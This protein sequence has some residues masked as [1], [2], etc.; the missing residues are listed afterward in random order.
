MIWLVHSARF[1]SSQASSVALDEVT[2]GDQTRIRRRLFVLTLATWFCAVILTGGALAQKTGGIL[3]IYNR[4]SAPSM[5]ILEEST[6][7]TVLPMM[8]VFNNLVVY[9]QHVAQNSEQS[10]LPDLATSWSWSEDGTQ[11]TFRLREGVKWHDG[12]PFTAKD[13][14]CT[15]DLLTDR[16][17]EKL[18]INPRRSWYSN[19][20][21]LVTNGD[22][23]A[24]FVLKRPQPALLALLASGFAPIYP[25][26]VSPREMRAHP[27]GTGP[28]KFVEFRPNEGI[29]VTRNPD[30]WKKG[31]P[32]LDGIE[33]TIIPNRSTALL[34]FGAGKFDM[35]WPY[36]VAIPLLKDVQNQTPQAICEITPLNASRNLIINREVAPFSNPEIR[37]A[38][39]L[40]LDRKAFIDILDEGQGDIGGALLPPPAGVWGLPPE[41][42]KGLPGYDPDVE[43]SRAE[44]RTIMEK[45]GYGAD[46]RLPVK[47]SVRNIPIARDPAVI[48][49]DQLKTIYIDAELDLIETVNWFPKAIRKDY[50][51][52]LNLTAAAVD[53]PDQQ[54]YE[55]Y[56]CGSARNITGYCNPELQKEFDRQS[57]EPDR[58]KR[59]KLVWEID[60]KLQEDGARPIIF[61]YRAASCRQPYVKGLTIMVNSIYN[62]WR[63]EDVW[64]DR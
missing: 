23:E 12:Q 42:L 47:L 51:V 56:A 57:M 52:G 30:Y 4:D 15:W 31:R 63:F 17:S 8:G 38:M 19:L 10:I 62:G 61:H 20:E 27:I 41:L 5:S 55:N 2:L 58:D 64:L 1:G 28:F 29:R 33:Y 18:R 54:F 11:L 43:K 40:S 46:K 21:E 3:K 35:T 50:A 39:A 36:D 14:K 48:L 45:Q 53:D 37:R 13:I 60:R 59:K 34:A 7:S 26:H 32:Y 49:I 25:C 44:A 6:L 24:T 9:D 22:Y 16:A